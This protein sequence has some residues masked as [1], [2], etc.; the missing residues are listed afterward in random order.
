M[1]AMPREA[2]SKISAPN[3]ASIRSPCLLGQRGD[4]F[5]TGVHVWGQFLKDFE[6]TDW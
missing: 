4:G 2:R 5:N 6:P 1:R 3:V